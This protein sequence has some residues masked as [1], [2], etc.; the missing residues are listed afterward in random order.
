[1]GLIHP[2]HSKRIIESRFGEKLEKILLYSQA[3]EKPI[4]I[5]IHN[6]SEANTKYSYNLMAESILQR[7]KKNTAKINYINFG[8]GMH[9]LSNEDISSAFKTVREIIPSHI[10]I[11]F[12]PGHAFCRDVGFAIAKIMSIKERESGEYIVTT[13]IS[14]E[15][16]LKW[17]IPKY[18]SSDL[19]KNKQYVNVIFYRI[20]LL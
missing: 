7:L 5:H 15:C 4:G 18:Y 19:G 8:G 11:I 20:K 10:S 17:S 9:T 13:D 14:Y 12:E 16:N 3:T 1:M 6:G 2:H